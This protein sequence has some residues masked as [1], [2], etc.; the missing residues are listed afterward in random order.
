MSL[1][2][3]GRILGAFL[4]ASFIV[5]PSDAWGWGEAEH[6][7]LGVDALR[8]VDGSTRSILQENWTAMR[9]E[10]PLLKGK[11]CGDMSTDYAR[12]LGLGALTMLAGDHACTTDDLAVS[13][14]YGDW[15][16]DVLEKT[17]VAD[18]EVQLLATMNIAPE[19]A[20]AHRLEIRRNLDVN[21]QSTDAKYLNR[22]ASNLSHYVRHRDSLEQT[23][24]EFVRKCLSPKEVS[25]ATSM[26]TLYHSKALHYA[27]QIHDAPP[28]GRQPLRWQAFLAEVFALHFLEDSFSAGHIGTGFTNKPE[29]L[30][31]HDYYNQH[32]GEFRTWR[33]DRYIG[34]GDAY[35]SRDDMDR[36]SAATAESLR[37]LAV[38]MDAPNDTVR[39]YGPSIHAFMQVLPHAVTSCT[40]SN[41]V[42]QVAVTIPDPILNVIRLS[43]QP[44]TA[45]H[46]VAK[47]QSE[48]GF[49]VPLHLSANASVN[50]YWFTPEILARR[51]NG[52]VYAPVR[53][54]IQVGFGVGFALDDAVSEYQDGLVFLFPSVTLG[55]G[56][57]PL[58][59][60]LDAPDTYIG[61]GFNV[62]AP[63][64]YIPGDF[65]LFGP[66]AAGGSLWATK[67][68]GMALKGDRSLLGLF[69]GVYYNG[70]RFRVQFD[71]G[72]EFS[73]RWFL[74]RVLNLEKDSIGSTTVVTA[75]DYSWELSRWELSFPAATI[76]LGHSFGNY[77]ANDVLV[78]FGFQVGWGYPQRTIVNGGDA[79][80][81]ASDVYGGLNVSVVNAAR[82]YPR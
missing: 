60:S 13:I 72:R 17:Q 76:R 19:D 82:F 68:L 1:W 26:Y 55:N 45:E 36:V 56:W 80:S 14:L 15:I 41:P 9:N 64:T 54:E 42:P 35:L 23:V 75:K 79:T 28:E 3:F 58:A 70:S 7:R 66:L 44:S 63:Y 40:E 65:L 6:V 25:N 30:G 5:A 50:P 21:M 62:R 10:N 32:G 24:S 81:T 43:P 52:R 4:S 8:R 59:N 78:R 67:R 69:H 57:L 29:R 48:F 34:F 12:C 38:F 2:N 33:G 61:L 18:T 73:F 20:Q 51:T 37:Q 53:A 74:N 11:L 77:H 31:T 46:G 22:A 16:F 47:F 71:L 49:F 27:M 39:Q